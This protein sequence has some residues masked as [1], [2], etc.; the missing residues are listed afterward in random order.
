MK[1]RFN[2]IVACCQK[3]GIGKDNTIPWKLKEEMD[4]FRKITT[5]TTNPILKNIVVMGRKTWESI[6]SKF[7][8]LKNRI[9]IVLTTDP[10]YTLPDDVFRAGSFDEIYGIIDTIQ[11]SNNKNIFVIGGESL[12]RECIKHK[13]CEKLYITKIYNKYDCDRFFPGIPE[14][15]KLTN[16]SDFYNENEIYSRKY[17]YTSQ[18]N[19]DITV[20]KNAEEYQYLDRLNK[21]I[22]MGNITTD[23]TG[24][25]TYSTF[26]ETFKYD[27]SETF[28]LL[29]TKKMWVRAIFEELK[30]YLSGKTDN[31][32][33]NE[34]GITIWDGNTTREFLD[35][36]GLGSYPVND[37]GESY[38]FN[39]RHYGAEYKTCKEDY[40]GKGF[41]Q[42][43]Y[44]IDLI[45]N[46]PSSRR[47][48]ID[49]WNCSTLH[50][51]ALPPCLCKYQFY[52]N[53]SENKLDIMIYM[54][55]S[56][57]FLANNWN[58]CTGAFLVYMI[59]NLE[60]IRYNPGVLTVITGDTHIYKSHIKQ[61]MENLERE[62]RPYPKLVVS[63][64]KKDIMDFEF[65]DFKLIGYDPYPNIKADMAV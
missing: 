16:V 23:R 42:V 21:I 17:I 1:H 40:T 62:P 3:G 5:Y 51:A 35:K 49:L 43:S 10:S 36:R 60:G 6:P 44:A 37:M 4:Y 61:V 33:L 53:K 57:F 47:I 52:V 65:S 59:C 27:I 13:N 50:R 31:S 32:I 48:I 41:D 2:I 12:Y 7:R 56:D 9:N 24:V 25:G 30:F 29:T 8:P 64:K 46:N 34:K 20:W 18:D 63:G 39:F 38:G 11:N 15:F 54:R 14:K 19:P 26:G 58:V 22:K 28:P 55:S 45:K